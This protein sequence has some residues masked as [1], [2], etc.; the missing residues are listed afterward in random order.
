MLWVRIV[1]LHL[2]IGIVTAQRPSM[3][4]VKNSSSFVCTETYLVA[5]EDYVTFEVDLAG[6]NTD[7]TYT[8]FY[9]PEFRSQKRA[10]KNGKTIFNLHRRVR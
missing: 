2:L 8:K 7:Y 6:N 1:L 4:V 3:I 10:M 9:W 5:G